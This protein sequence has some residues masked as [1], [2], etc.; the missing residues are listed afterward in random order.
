[1]TNIK[2]TIRIKADLFLE[3]F[4]PILY[5]VFPE[6]IRTS[7]VKSWTAI[8][9][10]N[11]DIF[12]GLYSGLVRVREGKAKRPHKTLKEWYD[13]TRFKW[14]NTKITN[15]NDRT[16]KPAIERENPEECARWA[17]MLLQAAEKAG[18]HEEELLSVILDETNA[19]AYKEWNG[20][21]LYIGDKV[22]IVIPAWYQNGKYVEQGICTLV[23]SGEEISA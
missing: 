3:R 9:I 2:K 14:E 16:L 21:D 1:M 22:E 18:L 10:D 23:S 15:L 7:F 4:D 20:A 17:A 19:N 8:L 13:R 12:S 11:A 5:L 6:R